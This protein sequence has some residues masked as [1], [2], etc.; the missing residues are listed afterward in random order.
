MPERCRIAGEPID[1]EQQRAARIGNHQV[2]PDAILKLPEHQRVAAELKTTWG[3]IDA[4]EGSYPA[5]D[6]AKLPDFMIQALF[7]AVEAQA[8]PMLV[9]VRIPKEKYNTMVLATV[10]EPSEV[11]EELVTRLGT[12]CRLHTAKEE[13]PAMPQAKRWVAEAAVAVDRRRLWSLSPLNS[14]NER[15][16]ARKP[17]DALKSIY[18]P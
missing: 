12:H 3:N 17:A 9:L 18:D 5:C 16:V 7:Q 11:A 14:Q 4:D 8:V 2:R 10:Y 13:W 15:V 1:E 6:P